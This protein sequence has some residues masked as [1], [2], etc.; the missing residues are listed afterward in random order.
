MFHTTYSI[1][2]APLSFCMLHQLKRAIPPRFWPR[3]WYHYAKGYL[4]AAKAKH[5]AR[6]MTVIGVTGTDGKTTTSSM[7]YHCL[8]HVG[9]KAGLLATTHFAWANHYEINET[10]KTSMSPGKLNHYLNQIKDAGMEYLVLESSSHALD[11]GRLVGIPIHTAVIT[12]LSHEH[13]DYHRTMEKYRRAKSKLFRHAKHGVI[14][15]D[16][17]FLA[18]LKNYPRQTQTFGKRPHNDL[19]FDAVQTTPAGIS[20]TVHYQ[21]K[22]YDFTLPLFGA[23]N[24]LNAIAAVA[25]CQSVG[26]SIETCRDALRTFTGVAGRMEKVSTDL[27]FTV[28]ID[29]AVTPQAFT[30]LFEAARPIDSGRLI[31]VFGAC[32]D[33][34]QLKRP[35]TG[36]IANQL[37]D[38]VIITDEEPYYED[39]KQIRDMIF[40]GIPKDTTKEIYVIADRTEAIRKAL[41][42]AKPHDVITVSGMGDQTSMVIGS[43]LIPW[44]DRETIKTIAKEIANQ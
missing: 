19:Y 34:D 20:F 37:C 13:L 10:H 32:G 12:N 41:S 44:S 4:H 33:R 40:S 9:K 23:H 26:V 28:L 7:I 43:Q 17:P 15:G 16:D 5:P 29:Y 8:N 35:I 2:V 3:L 1:L 22:T 14:F 6:S 30:A 38:A 27:P 39:A 42:I 24:A 25:A 18:P 36:K 21:N 11:Q 31:A